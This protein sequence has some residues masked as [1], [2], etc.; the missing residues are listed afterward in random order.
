MFK[1]FF[2]I[3]TCTCLFNVASE[4]Q[5]EATGNKQHKSE[6]VVSKV[7]TEGQELPGGGS[8][9]SEKEAKSLETTAEEPYFMLSNK[10]EE[11]EKEDVPKKNKHS[12]HHSCSNKHCGFC[13]IYER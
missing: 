5:M 9:K 2:L 7:S 12:L 4:N 13:N 1:H 11:V 3:Y 10:P 6:T 8:D